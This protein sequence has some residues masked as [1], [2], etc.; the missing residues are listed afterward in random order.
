MIDKLIKKLHLNPD[1]QDK[2]KGSITLKS[3]KGI[4]FVLGKKDD[5]DSWVANMPKVIGVNPGWN[6]TWGAHS[7]GDIQPP[8]IE[9][10]P[11]IWGYWGIEGLQKSI[12]AVKDLNPRLL[13]AFNEPDH[14]DQSNLPVETVVKVWHHLEAAEIPLVSPSCANPLGPWME[15][16]MEEVNR[17]N[18]RVDVI[19]VHSYGGANADSFKKM[20]QTVHEKYKRPVIIT[21]FA[22]ADW[23]AKSV[24][25]NKF[26]TA[27][28]LA[29]MKNVLPWLEEQ[30]WVIGYAWYPFPIESRAGACSALFHK[31][32]TL[33]ECGLYYSEF[34]AIRI[35]SQAT[36]AGIAEF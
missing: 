22:V 36:G 29:F 24:D 16:F 19:G 12:A 10:L 13:L 32:G 35:S 1:D 8:S 18:L 21:E 9:F 30:D 4:G 26:S 15:E 34:N 5:K 2:G 11:M 7:P 23:K 6:Y 31:D 28:V 27:Q 33:T 3:K 20:L 25:E 14:T 17:K